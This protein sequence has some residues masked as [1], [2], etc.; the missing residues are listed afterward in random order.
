[1]NRLSIEVLAA[2]F[3]LV[4][5]DRGQSL[6]FSGENETVLELRTVSKLFHSIIALPEFWS[7]YGLTTM[8]TVSIA[9]QAVRA[10]KWFSTPAKHSQSHPLQLSLA[11]IETNYTRQEVGPED[12][13]AVRRL[14]KRYADRWSHLYLGCQ[15]W[16]LLSGKLLSLSDRCRWCANT[17]QKQK[18]QLCYFL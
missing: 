11:T 12:M 14:L 3:R 7:A 9:T 15:G 18:R 2:I 13:A 5:H 8:S 6:N 17:I 1:M 10:V 16:N 4:V